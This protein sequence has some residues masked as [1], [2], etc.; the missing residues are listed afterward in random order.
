[1]TQALVGLQQQRRRTL[2]VWNRSRLHCDSDKIEPNA[3]LYV[4]I[5]YKL[6]GVYPD[7]PVTQDAGFPH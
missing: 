2:R 4:S 6:F 5:Y 3:K 1:M 7:L